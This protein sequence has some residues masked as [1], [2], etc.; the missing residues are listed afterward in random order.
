M[1]ETNDGRRKRKINYM[2]MLFMD[3]KEGRIR[4]MGFGPR[5]VDRKSVV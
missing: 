4:Q 5:L 2:L 3:S 1:N